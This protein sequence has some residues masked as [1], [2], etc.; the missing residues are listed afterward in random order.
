MAQVD[1][2]ARAREH[3]R[4]GH[5]VLRRRAREGGRVE[6]PLGDRHVLAL[7]REASEL[8]VRDLVAV[9]VEAVDRHLTRG[10]L[11]GVVVVRPHAERGAGDPDR[12]AHPA[13][14]RLQSSRMLTTVQLRRFAVSTIDSASGFVTE[15]PA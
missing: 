6:R 8:A 10:R 4:A 3:E 12:L 11:L 13:K 7:A 9:D 15:A 1:R 2:P 5:E 14:I